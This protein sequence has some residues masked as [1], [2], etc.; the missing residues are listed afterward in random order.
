MSNK[1]AKLVLLPGAGYGS[2]IFNKLIP[3]LRKYNIESIV[4]DYPR[5]LVPD[6]PPKLKNYVSHTAGIVTQTYTLDTNNTPIFICGDSKLNA[7]SDTLTWCQ[8]MSLKNFKLKTYY[9][10]PRIFCFPSRKQRKI[11]QRMECIHL[12]RRALC[13]QA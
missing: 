9:P 4:V 13:T 3:Q 12:S 10:Q 2:W 6:E 8:H 5:K 7:L 11:R 1:L